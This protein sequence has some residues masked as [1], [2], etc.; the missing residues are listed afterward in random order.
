MIKGEGIR[1][2]RGL[3]EIDTNGFTH[4]LLIEGD[5]IYKEDTDCWYCKGS[6]YP[7]S[8]CKIIRDDT[9]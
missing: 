9:K 8:I 4:S 7:S 5:W 2:F 6:S 3:M 1:A